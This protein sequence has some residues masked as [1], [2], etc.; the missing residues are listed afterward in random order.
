MK[1]NFIKFIKQLFCKHNYQK[2]ILVD[3]IPENMGDN[4]IVYNYKCS[5]C[6]KETTKVGY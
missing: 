2:Q 6:G 1:N 5:K 4:L 3:M